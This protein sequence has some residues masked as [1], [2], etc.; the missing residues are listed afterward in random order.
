MLIRFFLVSLVFASAV[1]SAGAD[2]DPEQ[3]KAIY[4]KCLVCHPIEAGKAHGVAP[5]LYGIVDKPIGKQK[6]FKYS[7]ALRKSDKVWTRENLDAF[8]AF[9][10]QVFPGTSMAFAGLKNGEEREQILCYLKNSE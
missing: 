3:G 4:E 10:M 2:C 9:P 8:L 6:G 5:N 1:S 7:K